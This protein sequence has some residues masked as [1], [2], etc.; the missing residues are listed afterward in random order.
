M[1]RGLGNVRGLRTLEDVVDAV[2]VQIEER[3][4]KQNDSAVES[5]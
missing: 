2:L 4:F 3:G 5:K 1:K